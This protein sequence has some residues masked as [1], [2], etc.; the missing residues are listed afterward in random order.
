MSEFD[1]LKKEYIEAL[2][3]IDALKEQ[4]KVCNKA[5]KERLGQIHSYMRENNLM[6]ADIGGVTF[7]R[8]EKTTVSVSMKTL[9][10]VIENPAD[11]EQYKRDHTTTK[12]SLKV[13]KPKRRRV[14]E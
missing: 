2:P 6:S 5:Q 10:E 3:E 8:E 11:L 14:E 4:L 9:E 13:R 12:E 1:D 7:E